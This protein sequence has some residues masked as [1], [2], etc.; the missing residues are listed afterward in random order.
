MDRSDKGDLAIFWGSFCMG[1][2]ASIHLLWSGTSGDWVLVGLKFLGLLGAGV[3]TGFAGIIG[4]HFAQEFIKERKR[5]RYER[6]RQ[7][8]R[9]RAA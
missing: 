5:I 9:D 1:G 6:K 3:T 8:E 4:K 2:T 7:K